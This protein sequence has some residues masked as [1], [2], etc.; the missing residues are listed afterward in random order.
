MLGLRPEECVYVGDS[1]F[2]LQAGHGAGCPAAA[3]LWGMFSEEVLLAEE[4]EAVCRDVEE[5][6]RCLL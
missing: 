1:P 3:A 2:D 5:L 6:R 4:P